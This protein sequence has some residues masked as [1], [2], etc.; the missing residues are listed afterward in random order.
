MNIVVATLHADAGLRL[1]AAKAPI[2]G[3]ARIE[4]AEGAPIELRELVA[5]DGVVEKISEIVEELQVGSDHVGAD[6][7]LTVLARL[8]PVARQAEAA[9]GAAI[10]RIERPETVDDT[11][12]NRS[13]RHLVGGIPAVGIGHAG[14][15]ESVGRGTLA[16]AQDAIDLADIVR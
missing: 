2:E 5:I 16:V 7:A 13:L 12:V 4:A 10:G 1:K 6:L 9:R 11:L 14:E 8:R 15:R 3:V